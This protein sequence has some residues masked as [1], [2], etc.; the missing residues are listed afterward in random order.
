MG[1]QG[2]HVVRHG[3]KSALNPAPRAERTLY[4][5]SSLH[6][7]LYRF[8]GVYAPR[9]AIEAYL[10][11]QAQAPR[12]ALLDPSLGKRASHRLSLSRRDGTLPALR[13]LSKNR[14]FTGEQ[15]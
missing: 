6:G 10:R 1:H 8:E 4:H 15:K 7:P 13:L 3:P 9:Q 11:Q 5:F 2:H 14:T 12:P